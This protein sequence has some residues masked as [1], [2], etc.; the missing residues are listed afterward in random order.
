[1]EAGLIEEL[2]YMESYSNVDN[3]KVIFELKL[4]P[5]VDRRYHKAVAED[6]ASK[7]GLAI[8]QHSDSGEEEDAGIIRWVDYYASPDLDIYPDTLNIGFEA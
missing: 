3:G 4:A 2:P 1:M 7:I 5:Y 6:L 8:N